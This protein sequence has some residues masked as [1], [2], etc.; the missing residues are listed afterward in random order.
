[1]ACHHKPPEFRQWTETVAG[2]IDDPVR[3]LRFLRTVSPA[4]K[5]SRS[6][7][8]R[9][10]GGIAVVSAAALAA[11]V[12]LLLSRASAR[13]A[14]IPV[15]PPAPR[16]PHVASVPAGQP[17]WQVEDRNGIEIYSNGLRIDKRS[18]VSNHPRSYLAFPVGG[19]GSPVR[20]SQPAGIVFHSTESQIA[21]F[22]AGHNQA[23]KRIG[24]SLLD[25]VR[26]RRSYHFLIDR[27]GRVYRVVAESDAADHAGYSVWADDTSAYVNLN[28]SFLGVAFEAR[29]DSARD[30][31]AITPAQTR[32][33]LMLVEMLR[34]RYR[35][36]A[37]NCVTH[38]QVSVNPSN[39][40]VGYHVDWAAGFPFPELGLPD[41]YTAALPSVWIFGFQCGPALLPAGAEAAEAILSRR[42]EALSLKPAVY[43]KRLHQLYRQKLAL[44]R[45]AGP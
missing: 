40:R 30:E 35:I 17:V 10:I 7:K 42:A 26:R 11:A 44:V 13:I 43:R 2:A 28:E 34:A 29:M 5:E 12:F 45:S 3:R 41:N 24:E 32:S 33:G 27:F 18:A 16:A 21:P 14:P 23:L 38:A 6:G 4:L 25:Y 37:A 31:P 1:M 9:R 19:A 20:H 39:M 36:P 8:G 22:E 15:L